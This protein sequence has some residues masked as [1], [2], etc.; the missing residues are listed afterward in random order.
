MLDLVTRV[1]V[2]PFHHPSIQIEQQDQAMVEGVVGEVGEAV[3]VLQL[4]VA[5]HPYL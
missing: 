2:L 3:L 1:M 5:K 4:M